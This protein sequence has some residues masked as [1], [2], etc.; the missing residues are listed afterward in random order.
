YRNVDLS[1]GTG[2]GAG[3]GRHE[4]LT[5]NFLIFSEPRLPVLGM[6]EVR[7]EAAYDSER[8]SMIQTTGGDPNNEMMMGGRFFPRRAY[9]NGGG[10]KQTSLQGSLNLQRV[11]EKATTIKLLKGVVPL[12]LLVEQVPVSLA[13]DVLKAKGKKTTVGE[14]EFTVDNVTKKAAGQFD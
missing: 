13:D 11:S 4:S 5:L 3:S 9:Y 2:H 14:L 8:N 10:A 12:T 1:A 7:L 6:G